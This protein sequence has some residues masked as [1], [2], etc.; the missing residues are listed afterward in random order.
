MYFLCLCSLD[1]S[2]ETAFCKEKRD[3]SP[4]FTFWV[5][6]CHNIKNKPLET[7]RWKES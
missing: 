4:Y 6:K 1:E 5:E 7:K 2:S 3:L